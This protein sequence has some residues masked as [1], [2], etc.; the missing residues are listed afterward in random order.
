MLVFSSYIKIMEPTT[1]HK[2]CQIVRQRSAGNQKSCSLLCANR[3][4]GQAMSILRQELDSLIRCIYLLSLRDLTARD[5]LADQTLNGERWRYP[6]RRIV[7]D[8]D[9][10]QLADTLHGWTQSVYEFGCAFVH[11]S[12]FHD[13][14][15]NDPLQ[16]LDEHDVHA[17]KRH[18]NYY[19]GYNLNQTLTFQSVI[20]YL[21]SVFD[22]VASNLV[23]YIERLESNQI[24]GVDRL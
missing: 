18:L 16:S 13:Y 21:P 14:K 22:K 2:F 4:Y 5:I 20:P 7:T 10:V 6:G 9:M 12:N 15:E 3:L 11:L 17:I 23:C 19:H 8:R 1:I 24:E